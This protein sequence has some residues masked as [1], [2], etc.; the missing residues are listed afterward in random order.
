MTESERNL[1]ERWFELVWNQQRR[2]AIAEMLAP[3]AVLH[4][5]AIDTVGHQGFY[6]FFDRMNAA[7]SELHVSVAD[8]IAEG[9]KVCVRWS[10]TAKH[11][12]SGLGIPPSGVTIHVTGVTLIRVAGGKIVEGWQNWD[13]LGMMEQINAFAQPGLAK[14]A[15]YIGAK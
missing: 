7:F 6:D 4:D 10:C 8:T 11:S 13:M 2:E 5:G 15:T 1:G 3:S 12:G 14:S 9:D